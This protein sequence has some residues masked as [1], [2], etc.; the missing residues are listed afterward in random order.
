MHPL[1]YL[2]SS[3]LSLINIALI[4]YIVISLLINFNILN[5]H[6]PLVSRVEYALGRLLEPL[7]RPIRQMLPDMGGIDLSPIV[8]ILL[9]QFLEYALVYYL[10]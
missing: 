1:I 9:L 4:V 8:I 3:V 10:A 5:R 7:L 6:Q 2:L